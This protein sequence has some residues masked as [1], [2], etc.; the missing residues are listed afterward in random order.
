MYTTDIPPDIDKV[1]EKLYRK[2]KKQYDM[3]FSKIDQIELNPHHFK[4][5]RGDLKGARRV[6]IDKSF[7][8]VY[9]IDEP[10]RI[11]RVIDF[12]HHDNIYKK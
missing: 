7:V 11:V 9:E 1:F 8:L 10:L 3:I 2:N 6:H 4:P 12:D 5:L